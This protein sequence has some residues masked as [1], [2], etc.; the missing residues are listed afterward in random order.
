MTEDLIDQLANENVEIEIDSD[1]N[2][3]NNNLDTCNSEDMDV[4][5][6]MKTLT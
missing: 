2:A 1:E 5:N 3:E 6:T 4:E